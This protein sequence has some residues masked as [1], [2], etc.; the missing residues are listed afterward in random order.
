MIAIPPLNFSAIDVREFK[1]HLFEAIDAFNEIDQPL[2][3]RI[4]DFLISGAGNEVLLD[5]RAAL[6]EPSRPRFFKPRD[7]E[8]TP[9]DFQLSI[10]LLEL[11]KQPLVPSG[12]YQ[13]LGQVCSQCPDLDRAWIVGEPRLPK[14]FNDLIRLAVALKHNCNLNL[15]SDRTNCDLTLVA[16]DLTAQEKDQLLL[17]LLEHELSE[18][19]GLVANLGY[20]AAASPWIEQ[21]IER[22]ME[23]VQQDASRGEQLVTLLGR[24]WVRPSQ[25]LG[26]VID[27]GLGVSRNSKGD[28][29][30]ILERCR[31]D[32]RPLLLRRL[33]DGTAQ[34]RMRAAEW[35]NKL[36]G[37]SI[38]ANLA[39]ALAKE[40][41]KKVASVID[42]LYAVY[43]EAEEYQRGLAK[44]LSQPPVE[45]ETGE[46]P[47]PAGFAIHFQKFLDGAAALSRERYKRELHDS[48][49]GQRLD[50]KPEPSRPVPPEP[51]TADDLL[52]LYLTMEGKSDTKP[53]RNAWLFNVLQHAQADAW[54]DLRELKLLHLWRLLDAIGSL[55]E[56]SSALTVYHFELVR[57][58]RQAQKV[59]YGL[60]EMDAAAQELFGRPHLMSR[61]YLMEAARY[62]LEDDAI[63]PA[64][65]DQLKLLEDAIAGVPLDQFD[66]DVAGR[67][68]TALAIAAMLPVLPKQIEDAAW[69]L[70]LSDGWT[71]RPLARPLLKLQANCA[72]RAIAALSHRSGGAR[73]GA[74]EILQELGAT[75]AIGPLKKALNKE[76]QRPVQGY[77]LTALEKLG[78]NVDEFIGREKLLED[79]TKGNQRLLRSMCW[80]P[81]DKLPVV[82]WASDNEP[83]PHQV[84]RWWM[85]QCVEF[86]ST[87]CSPIMRRA[88]ELCRRDDTLRLAHFILDQW[89]AFDT[90]EPQRAE[91]EKHIRANT[92]KLAQV[93]NWSA[94][95]INV[96]IESYIDRLV[97]QEM[98]DIQR[99]QS[100]HTERGLLAIV[101]AFGDAAC[102]EKMEKY[103]RSYHGN[104]ALQAKSMLEVIPQINEPISL[105]VIR[106]LAAGFRNAAICKR[107]GELFREMSQRYGWSEDELAERII[108]D[109]GFAFPSVAVDA[110]VATACPGEPGLRA[111]AM[112]GRPE[113]VLN[114]GPRQFRAVVNDAFEVLLIDSHGKQSKE[115]P[116]PTKQDDKTLVRVAKEQLKS[117]RA[118][119]QTTKDQLSARLFEAMCSHRAWS[120]GDWRG[121]LVE[122][123]LA[124]IACRRV[125]WSW[126][127]DPDALPTF[128]QVLADGSAIDAAGESLVLPE[129]GLVRVAHPK[130]M[131]PAVEQFWVNHLATQGIRPLIPQT[132]AA[133]N[134]QVSPSE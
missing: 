127:I 70:A 25:C 122:H 27:Y 90:D 93:F 81:L 125:V 1:L 22:L 118:I 17:C 98:R 101:A 6:R 38:A 105:R 79:A 13:R 91:I 113:M 84:L 80:F 106:S 29:Q 121:L 83:L 104:R 100:A 42:Q 67:R 62:E 71:L 65:V 23:L 74:A 95:K 85:I 66:R 53:P 97:Q 115:L 73:M 133:L 16:A 26:E 55:Q 68:Q 9:V 59:P 87:T 99:Q 119:V 131:G 54:C 60:R 89:I 15:P 41:D 33:V 75:E 72:Q 50:D 124:G 19:R 57:A 37:Q 3:V 126:Q 7:K 10:R 43:R 88:L 52:A 20:F 82:R 46:L 56:R 2:K 45:I 58:H 94:K 96:E 12:Y 5:L 110:D 49:H 69:A 35:L 132:G 130:E 14:W 8:L 114:Y 34:Q 116:P 123:V 117:S 92:E 48:V 31:V 77:L 103:I 76:K 109:A 32:A 107:A 39:D 24:Y 47:L 40:T 18:Q 11:F 61:G 128:F 134:A 21:N 63:W 28:F 44:L 36:Y 64:F 120:V 102:V 86:K 129:N 108:P 51:P 111:G 112:V 30:T 4:I 78:A